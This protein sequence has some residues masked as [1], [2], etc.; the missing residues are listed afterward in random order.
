MFSGSQQLFN[1]YILTTFLS[2][3]KSAI[4]VISDCYPVSTTRTGG[5]NERNHDFGPGTWDGAAAKFQHKVRRNNRL[6]HKDTQ[7]QVSMKLYSLEEESLALGSVFEKQPR[8]N[9]NDVASNIYRRTS[10]RQ[11]HN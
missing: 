8:D 6:L 10:N 9:V 7:L 11:N 2:P 3:G 5:N 1:I 4:P